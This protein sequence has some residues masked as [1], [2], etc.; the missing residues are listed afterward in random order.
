MINKSRKQDSHYLSL[1]ILGFLFI[2]KHHFFIRVFFSLWICSIFISSTLLSFHLHWIYI[3][4]R[5]LYCIQRTEY[6]IHQI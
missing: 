2:Y 4:I 6:R 5:S 1:L 3:Q